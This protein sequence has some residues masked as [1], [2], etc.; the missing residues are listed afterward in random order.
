MNF[1][2]HTQLTGTFQWP[3]VLI[4]LHL[5][6]LSQKWMDLFALHEEFQYLYVIATTRNMIDND[7][8]KLLFLEG[9]KLCNNDR[10]SEKNDWERPRIHT[11]CYAALRDDR[12][13]KD[14]I[15]IWFRNVLKSSGNYIS[16]TRYKREDFIKHAYVNSSSIRLYQTKFTTKAS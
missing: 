4:W 16:E 7:G 1:I 12:Q 13:I 11:F 15:A 10:Y 2:F 9:E 3:G 6:F 8:T 5:H 14:T